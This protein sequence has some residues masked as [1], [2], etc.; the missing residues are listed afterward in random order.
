VYGET[1]FELVDQ[2]IQTIEF[3]ADDKFIDLGSGAFSLFVSRHC[4]ISYLFYT[5]A[6]LYTRNKVTR[7]IKKR[8][9]GRYLAWTVN[10]GSH[11]DRTVQRWMSLLPSLMSRDG[12]IL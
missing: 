10:I 2:M 12:M 6:I 11:P 9:A 5:T 4:S 1:S 3:T 7:K 8:L